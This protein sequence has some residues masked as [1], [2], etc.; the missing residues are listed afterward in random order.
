[1]KKMPKVEAA[2]WAEVARVLGV[3]RKTLDEWRQRESAPKT[4]D[5]QAW[6]VYVEANDLGRGQGKTF[7]ALRK[8]K[9]TREVELMDQ[10]L[11]REKQRVIPADE[12]KAFDVAYAAK[13]DGF[14]KVKLVAEMPAR[15]NGKTVADT[16]AEA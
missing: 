6:K 2:T 11:A 4:A 16:R 1:M 3:P 14:L 8:E 10:K 7:E 13:L 9:L 5:V 15:V 12:V